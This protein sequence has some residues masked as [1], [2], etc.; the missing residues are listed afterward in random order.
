MTDTAPRVSRARQDSEA[1]LIAAA[2]ELLG[3]VGPRTMSV[4]AIADRAGVNHGLVH[5]Y[6]GG[7]DGLLRAAMHHLVQEHAEFARQQS[8]GSPLPAPLALSND[9]RY[10]R[11]VVRSVLDD[12][13]ELAQM[14]LTA[15]VSVPRGALQHALEMRKMPAAD[16][17]TKALLAISM[18]ME[19]GWAVLEPFLFAVAEVDDAE[20][21][22]TVRELARDYRR[23]LIRKNLDEQL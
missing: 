20:E 22:E 16:A 17:Q 11:A 1:K 14:E 13:M 8:G 21:Q 12:E 18:A 19:M 9:Q 10:L 6:F 2:A 15:G 23:G 7:K 5:H 4:R 3:E